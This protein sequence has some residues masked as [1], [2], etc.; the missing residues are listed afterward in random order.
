MASCEADEGLS[1]GVGVE[2]QAEG[3]GEG[4]LETDIPGDMGIVQGHN[5][6]DKSQRVQPVLAA[7]HLA[8]KE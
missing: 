8:G 7:S 3:G 2:Y 5:G 6:G 1:K 4:E